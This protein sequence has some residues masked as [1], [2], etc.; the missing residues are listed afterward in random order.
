MLL[1]H[2]SDAA[3]WSRRRGDSKAP[4]GSP[5]KVAVEGEIRYNTLEAQAERIAET[6]SDFLVSVSVGVSRIDGC[7]RCEPT[8]PQCTR[9][10][11]FR[12]VRHGRAAA[13]L[14]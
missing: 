4:V 12:S 8:Q 6:E 14:A 3:H 11:A 5:T 13:I 9:S 7:P 1:H 10:Q 2:L